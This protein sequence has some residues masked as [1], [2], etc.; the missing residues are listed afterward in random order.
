MYETRTR[1]G[2]TMTKREQTKSSGPASSTA[3]VREMLKSSLEL[4]P[5]VRPGAPVN[6][7]YVRLLALFG[8]GS[9]TW[10]DQFS[11][12]TVGFWV[13]QYSCVLTSYDK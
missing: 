9:W 3:I 4:A 13:Y 5:P 8:E 7:G 2:K 10:K 6:I 12:G 1:Q 11:G